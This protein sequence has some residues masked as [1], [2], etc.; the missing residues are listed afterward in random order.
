[1]THKLLVITAGTI[2]AGVGEEFA[3]QIATHKASEL[4]V[5]VR[6]LDTSRLPTRYPHILDGEWTQM[7][8]DPQYIDTVR[9][10]R[11]SYPSLR[12][13]LYSGLLP[14]IQGSG[15]GSIRYNAAGAIAINRDRIK[16]WLKAS[17]THLIA[18][19]KGQ[20]DLSVAIVISA[21]GATGSGTLERLIDIIVETT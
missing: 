16:R 19:D 18:S 1:M 15:G 7:T 5:L 4:Q 17:I 14:T 9:R 12:N 13:L 3:K 6:Y 20:V 21:V 2:A 10:N 11:E 8:I